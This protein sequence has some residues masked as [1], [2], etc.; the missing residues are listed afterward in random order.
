MKNHQH[1]TF[2]GVDFLE[3]IPDAVAVIEASGKIEQVNQRLEKMFGY[4]A[5]GLLGRNIEV[6]AG[7]TSF[8]DQSSEHAQSV[9]SVMHSNV[10]SGENLYG[11]RN[12]GST[13]LVDIIVS[14]LESAPLATGAY[15][16]VV[17]RD[18]SE[19]NH[20]QEELRYALDDYHS[21]L[22][23]VADLIQSVK[24]DGSIAFVNRSW[25]DALGY[26]QEEIL[27]LSVFDIITID[28]H[29][30]CHVVLER[31]LA[32]EDVGT[33]ESRFVKKN[34]S[35]IDVEGR[36]TLRCDRLG[37]TTTTGL[38]R[39]ITERKLTESR[40][41]EFYSIVSHELRSPLTSIN[42]SVKLIESGVLGVV[43]DEIA[44]LVSIASQETDRLLHLIN[45]ML[46]MRK[47]E[48]GKFELDKRLFDVRKLV[49][50]VLEM[51]QGM[52]SQAKVKLKSSVEAEPFVFADH[53]RIFQ[54]LVNLVSN[55]I[56]FSPADATVLVKT[57]LIKPQVIRF[58]VIDH[59]AGIAKDS[60]S[61]LFGKFQ[62]LQ[63]ADN[64]TFPG[65]GLG[66]AISKAI[67]EEHGGC[68]GVE[69]L[70][71]SGSTFWFQLPMS[72]RD[73]MRILEM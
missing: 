12:D 5:S 47:I 71:G 21:I 45:D 14:P 37:R 22:D 62:Q 4:S 42:G 18:A 66:L 60:I 17:V 20:I 15:Y 34:G 55:A 44:E 3:S 13:L 2:N 27:N 28:Q 61:K 67:V 29:E 56:K 70:K 65:S 35:V 69:S 36:I 1:A 46:D 38:F 10:Y 19:R 6:I 41:K 51:M 31:L 7:R 26:S 9:S 57:E 54:T 52:A 59:G 23:G 63:T 49:T 53:D 30:H 16:L 33:V 40:L 24:P 68:I 11:R 25:M 58:S 73:E 43:P 8:A 64:S 32:G 72:Q 50:S 39:D 48:I